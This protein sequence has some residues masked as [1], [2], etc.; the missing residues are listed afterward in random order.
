MKFIRYDE[1]DEGNKDFSLTIKI[2]LREHFP[3]SEEIT[4]K[5]LQGK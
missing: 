2:T 5:V 1:E 3:L 4:R